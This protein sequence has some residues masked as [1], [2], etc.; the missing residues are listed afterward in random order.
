M[1]TVSAG[2][3]VGVALTK[4]RVDGAALDLV[5][6]SADLALLVVG[7]LVRVVRDV[8]APL[9]QLGDGGFELRH[10]GADV[11]QLDDVRLGRLGELAEIAQ[12]VGH[13]LLV[14]EAVGELREYPAGERD[15][16]GLDLDT[17]GTGEGLDDRK[18]RVRGERGRLVGKRVDDPHLG[19]AP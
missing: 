7:G 19:R 4:D 15:V 17:G 10:R 14:V 16:A 18:Q 11:R 2:A 5:V 12:R 6:V 1:G 13:A 8:I 3:T 9:L